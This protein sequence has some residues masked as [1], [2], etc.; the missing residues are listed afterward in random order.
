MELTGKLFFMERKF[1]GETDRSL[2]EY[3]AEYLGKKD[4]YVLWNAL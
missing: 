4:V 3:V 1:I 2:I